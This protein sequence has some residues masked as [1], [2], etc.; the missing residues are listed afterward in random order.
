MRK[1]QKYMM[2]ATAVFYTFCI[3]NNPLKCGGY[4]ISNVS[5]GLAGAVLLNFCSNILMMLIQ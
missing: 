3:A 5:N 4:M 1:M 2:C